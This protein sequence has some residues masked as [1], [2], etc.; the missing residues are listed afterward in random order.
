MAL[1]RDIMRVLLPMTKR[2]AAQSA[3]KEIQVLFW[4]H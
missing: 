2:A 1:V 3:K 4:S